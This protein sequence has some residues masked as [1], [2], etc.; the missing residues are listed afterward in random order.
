MLICFLTM[1]SVGFAED[2]VFY[3]IE[4]KEACADESI[5]K[6]ES[7]N[8]V[9]QKSE[10]PKVVTG[11]GLSAWEYIKALFALA[12]VVGLLY[13]LLKFVNNKNRLYQ[14]NRLMKNLGG[15]SLGQQKSIQ[16]V[17]IGEAYYLIGVGD[18]IR[19]L[20]EITDENEI[21]TLL[22]YYEETDV[23]TLKGPLE[24]VLTKF[25]SLKGERNKE[26][27]EKQTDFSHLFRSRLD[28]IKSERNK[29]LNQITKK[30]R[31]EDE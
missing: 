13:A 1:P 23:N 27:T 6:G 7:E 31:D 22:E 14:K 26:T 25:S 17:V 15:I 2:N 3:C 29:Q 20:K 24:Q 18:D 8:S 30:E 5:Q 21:A 4:N 9:P 19:L 11:T 10:A 16:L 28:E 12:F